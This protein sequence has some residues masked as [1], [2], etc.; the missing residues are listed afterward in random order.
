LKHYFIWRKLSYLFI[1]LNNNSIF[2][3]VMR[4]FF[5]MYIYI[6]IYI[7]SAKLVINLYKW[8]KVKIRENNLQ[9]IKNL[10]TSQ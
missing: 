3:Y 5:F 9:F 6:Y 4:T 10:C 8:Y 2:T 1:F 7:T